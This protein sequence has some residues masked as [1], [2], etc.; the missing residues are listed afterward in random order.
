MNKPGLIFIAGP[1]ASGKSATATALAGAL[2]GEIINADAMQ[3]YNDLNIITA[4]PTA[5]EEAIAPHHLYGAL[6]ASERCSAGRWSR[7]AKVALDQCAAHGIVAL[8]CGGTGLY[9]RALEEGLSPVPETPTEVR[10]LAQARRDRLGPEAFRDEVVSQDLA[11]ERF[12]AGD[13]QRLLRAWEVFSA[14]GKPLSWHQA[15]PRAPIVGNVDARIIIEP[16]RDVLYARCDARAAMMMEEGAIDEVRT[17]LARNLDPSLP[18]MKA[19]GVPEIAAMLRGEVDAKT[20]LETLQ[21]NTRRFAKRQLT[22]FRNQAP[23]WP[24]AAS[25]EEAERRLREMLYIT[26]K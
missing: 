7:L 23:D 21:Q 2:N 25:A 9:F 14:T 8:V 12:P 22:W 6:D 11:M 18:V 1:T 19:L 17:L 24:R 20:A 10:A 4:R 3:V 5:R 15:R 13:A 16:P 26:G